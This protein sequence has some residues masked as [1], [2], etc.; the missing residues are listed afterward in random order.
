MELYE[1]LLPHLT[2]PSPLWCVS[3]PPALSLSHTHLANSS[4]DDV[5]FTRLQ[6]MAMV[7]TPLE[8][9]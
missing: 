1:S 2:F 4:S 5:E 8:C 6:D 3:L 7:L 9:E